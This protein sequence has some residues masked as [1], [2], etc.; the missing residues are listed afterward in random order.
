M[1]RRRSPAAR[2]GR[3]AINVGPDGIARTPDDLVDGHYFIRRDPT[4]KTPVRLPDY[5]EVTGNLSISDPTFEELPQSLAVHGDLVAR[6]MR[7]YAYYFTNR[8]LRLRR[9]LYDLY[10]RMIAILPIVQ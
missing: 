8:I 6:L 9:P 10:D 5:L 4:R 7:Q 1:A 3:A 2:A